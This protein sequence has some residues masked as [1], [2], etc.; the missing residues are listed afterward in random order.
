M[1]MNRRNLIKL[2]SA[3]AIGLPATGLTTGG[4]T[5]TNDPRFMMYPFDNG[6]FALKCT[7][8]SRNEGREVSDEMRGVR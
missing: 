5:S 6:A 4:A 7:L 2:T 3:A 1:K 8:A